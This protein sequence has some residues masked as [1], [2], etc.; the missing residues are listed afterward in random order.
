MAGKAGTDMV[1]S[2][3]SLLDEDDKVL[4]REV[5]GCLTGLDY[6]PQKQKVQGYVLSFKNQEVNQAIAKIGVRKDSKASYSIKFYACKNPPDRFMKAL[7]KFII[8]TKERYKCTDCGLCGAAAG[9]R[10]YSYT[11]PDGREFLQCGAYVVEI[12]GLA[13]A[14]IPELKKLL[15]EQHR[16]FVSR[17]K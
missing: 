1:V 16:Y 7:E 12:P 3:F 14:D 15:T 17:M 5:I 11:Y 4:C 6:F 13:P 2:L 10:G 8:S 9:E